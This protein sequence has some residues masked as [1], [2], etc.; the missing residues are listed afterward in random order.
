MRAI[1]F[2]IGIEN[3]SV[4]QF[5][6]L[7]LRLSSCLSHGR[8]VVLENISKRFGNFCAVKHL[9]LRIPRGTIFGLL[10][11]VLRTALI[12]VPVAPPAG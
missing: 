9:P 1:F 7:G 12:V 4:D 2:P 3:A 10:G 8:D 11:T 6:K 5:P